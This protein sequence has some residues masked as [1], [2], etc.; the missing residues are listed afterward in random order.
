MQRKA[1]IVAGAA[2]SFDAAK[3]VLTRFGFS[4]PSASTDV[5]TAL[6]E[7][8]QHTYDLL[9]LPL[10]ELDALQLAAVERALRGGRVAFT[11]G[12]APRAG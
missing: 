12:T 5:S 6:A 2:G 7:L 8:H 10:Q 1:L 3:S 9:V 11:I 4:E